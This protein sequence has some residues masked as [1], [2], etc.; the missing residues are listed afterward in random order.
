MTGNQFKTH[1]SRRAALKLLAAE[2]GALA[3]TGCGLSASTQETPTGQ[4]S[5]TPSITETALATTSSTLQPTE[6]STNHPAAL[7]LLPPVTQVGEVLPLPSPDLSNPAPLMAA[8]TLRCSTRT[9]LPDALPLATLS[10]L[11]WAGF[12]VNRPG[13]G[14]RTAPSAYNMQDLHIYPATE[15]GLWLYDASLHSLVAV[16]EADLRPLTNPP[17]DAPVQLIYVSRYPAGYSAQDMLQ[18]SWAHTGFIAQNVYL[19]SA[20]AGLA[21]VVRSS[22]DHDRLAEQMSL[23]SNE[24]ITLVQ[25]VGMAG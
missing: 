21:T 12:G 20:A 23:Q 17:A 13:S 16:L 10:D 18:Y 8:L 24:H 2:A 15:G 19:Y 22:F 9:C 1:M 14:M 11:L 25:A 5:R 3:L 7:G 6:S 4:P